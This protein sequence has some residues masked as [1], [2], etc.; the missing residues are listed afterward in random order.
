MLQ[1]NTVLFITLSL[2][3]LGYLLKRLDI[4]SEND[5]TVLSKV[6]MH[7]TFPALMFLSMLR[8]HLETH[9]FLIPIISVAL[10]CLMILIA[11]F[12]FSDMP[13]KI[14]GVLTMS[15][16]SFNSGLFGFPVVEGIWGREGLVYAIMFD[17]GVTLTVFCMVYIIGAYFATKGEGKVEIKIILKKIARLI[18][19][20]AAII[21][22]TMNALGFQLPTII[23]DFLEILAK[24]N[25]PLVLLL[26]GIYLNF[27]FEKSQLLF[28]SKALLIRYS[29]GLIVAALFYFI[30]SPSLFR[31]IMMI[32][33]ILPVGLT[34]IP[35]S[36]EFN[37]DTKIAGALVN[38]SLLISFILLWL[39]VIEFK[40]V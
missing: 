16:G 11:W 25:K 37:F 38:I 18:P 1:A 4:V 3:F 36:D 33:V 22:L 27:S 17:I 19:F 40:M 28:I 9:L 39:F 29:C 5:G 32:C 26:M 34:L 20:Q 13:N 30:L 24:A 7:T 35:F 12:W 6:L 31:N 21:G 2:I 10:G 8:I 15:V 14:R 23:T